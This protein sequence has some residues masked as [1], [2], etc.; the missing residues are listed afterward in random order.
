VVWVPEHGPD[1]AKEPAPWPWKINKFPFVILK[2]SEDVDKQFS[3]P[4][5]LEVAGIQEELEI[6]REEIAINTV[7]SRP[8]NMY[9][10]NIIDETKMV[11]ISGR[12]KNANIP[13]DGMLGM[14]NSPIRRESTDGLTQEYYNHYERNRQELVENLGSSQNEALRTTKSTAAEAEIVNSNAGTATSAKIDILT[15]FMDNAIEIAIDIMKDVY[16]TP[17]VSQVVGRDNVKRWV[18]WTG[19]QI[20]KDVRV[21]IEAGSTE[22]EDSAYNRQVS[23]NMLETMKSVPG[24]DILQLAVE[25]LQEHG[26]RNAEQYRLDTPMGTTTPQPQGGHPAGVG[27]TQGANVQDSLTNQMSPLV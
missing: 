25:V 17:R 12:G 10:S 14:P 11:Q 4:P 16:D 2:F 27:P 3:K 13:I 24:I 1:C 20:L 5:V 7:Y 6:Q 22:R 9:D 21:K 19:S 26:K 18:Q 15:D 23:L 8:Y